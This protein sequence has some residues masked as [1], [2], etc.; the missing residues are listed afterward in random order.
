MKPLFTK[1]E[2]DQVFI[3]LAFYI[4]FVALSFLAFSKQSSADWQNNSYILGAI[5]AIAGPFAGAIARPSQGCCRDWALA[6]LP[7]CAAF[8]AFG[9]VAQW[10]PLPFRSMNH[11]VRLGCWCIGLLG[12]FAGV[13]F[14]LAHALS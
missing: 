13:P 6:I 2:K 9:G 14:S 1:L 12:W 7:Y 5:G 11:S 4:F 10:V 3:A 8:L